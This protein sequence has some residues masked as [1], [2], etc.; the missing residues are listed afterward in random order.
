MFDQI[1]AQ[2]TTEKQNRLVIS[3]SL[4]RSRHCIDFIYYIFISFY[5][6]LIKSK[7]TT[8]GV[9]SGD[10]LINTVNSS[11][12]VFFYT[13]SIMSSDK[14]MFKWCVYI[15]PESIICWLTPGF[16][17]FIYFDLLM[18]FIYFLSFNVNYLSSF[19]FF[20][21]FIYTLK[22]LISAKSSE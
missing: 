15:K 3:L 16:D 21:L 17:L 22:N 10:S 2:I 13:R 20:L 1:A 14:N 11:R 18:W 8:N 4:R 6:Y 5:L 7:D 9:K 12:W 19:I